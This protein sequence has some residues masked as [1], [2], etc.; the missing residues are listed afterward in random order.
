MPLSS[1]RAI[2]S[3]ESPSSKALSVRGESRMLFLDYL[4]IFAFVS[5][6]I[7]HRY[8]PNLQAIAADENMH[9]SARAFAQL[10][11][12]LVQMGGAGVVVFF[13]VSGYIITHV[14]QAETARQFAIKRI[15]RIYPLYVTALLLNTFQISVHGHWP[16]WSVLRPQVLLVGDLFGSPYALNGVEWTLRMEVAFYAFMAI[17]RAFGF[18]GVRSP[19]LPVILGTTLVLAFL[20]PPIP[21][22]NVWNRGYLSLYFPFLILGA[23]VYLHESAGL[24]LT[25]LLGAFG[26]VLASYWHLVPLVQKPALNTHFAVLASALFVAAWAA[27]NAWRPAPWVALLS[28]LTYS[29]Y[30]FHNW[31]CD[32][33]QRVLAMVMADGLALEVTTVLVLLAICWTAARLIERPGVR[34]GRRL[35]GPARSLAPVAQ[36]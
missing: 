10:L 5:V 11:L 24:S 4:R 17:L 33:I 32:E 16:G 7:G 3:L 18:A 6:L 20:L 21:S 26:L 29:V 8:S 25:L 12:P 36:A 35:A 34:L 23:L 1:D 14:L 9:A 15:F 27:R 13:F 19:W 30:L 2:E 28:E 31:L 22:G